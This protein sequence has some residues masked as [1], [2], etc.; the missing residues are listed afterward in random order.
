MLRKSIGNILIGMELC[1]A[2][3][4]VKSLGAGRIY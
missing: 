3:E 4:N 2:H 1:C